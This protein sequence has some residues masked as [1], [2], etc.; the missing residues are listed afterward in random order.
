MR[1]NIPELLRFFDEKAPTSVGHASAIVSVIGEDL[2]L[3]LLQRCL[4]EKRD[5]STK[6]IMHGGAPLTP[7]LGTSRGPR[8]DRWLLADAT[9][10]N[11]RLFQVEIKNWSAHAIGGRDIPKGADKAFLKKYRQESWR[12]IWDRGQ[13]CFRYEECGKVLTRMNIPTKMDNESGQ[14]VSILPEIQKEDVEPIICFWWPIHHTGEDESLFSYPLSSLPESGFKSVCVFSMSNYLRSISE[15]EPEITLHM[16]A[17][18][19]R[20]EWLRRLVYQES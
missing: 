16:P 15:R 9:S 17:A 3:A 8:L 1:L 13:D 12:R 5:V 20:I 7:T 19:R 14:S 2:G 4:K 6:V 18:A 10:T 11:A